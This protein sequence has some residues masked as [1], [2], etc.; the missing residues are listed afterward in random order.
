V[1]LESPVVDETTEAAIEPGRIRL[2]LKKVLLSP[3]FRTSLRCQTFLAYLVERSLDGQAGSLK[4]RALAVDVFGRSAEANLA[5]D[6]IVRVSARE[7]RRRLAQYYSTA[8][9]ATEDVRIDLPTGSY[10]PLVHRV[11][12]PGT[13]AALPHSATETTRLSWFRPFRVWTAVSVLG[14]LSYFAVAPLLGVSALD[15]FWSPLL[16]AGKTVLIVV[17]TPVVYQASDRARRLNDARAGVPP[18]LLDMPI[19][20][21]PEKL[22]G[23]DMVP[24]LDKHVGVGNLLASTD[25]VDFFAR[26][27]RN[28]RVRIANHVEFLDLAESPAILIGAFSNRWTV[29]LNERLHFRFAWAP[30]RIPEIVEAGGKRIWTL[31]SAPPPDGSADEDF[32]LVSRLLD[33]SVRQ[34]TLVVAG[35]KQF[36]TGAGGRLVVDPTQLGGVLSQLPPGWQEKSLQLVLR[37][38]V[39]GVGPTTPELVASYVW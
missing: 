35:I 37:A 19:D 4:E 25:L 33:G 15:A 36:G 7:V 3:A 5:E 6:T 12:G 8:E 31:T 2:H 16:G 30:G 29:E 32:V 28:T 39:I 20:V 27:K 18:P 11:T 26:R 17:G 10:V 23:S 1:R 22:D 34:P 38:R 9:A 13:K 14:A 24:V 21:P